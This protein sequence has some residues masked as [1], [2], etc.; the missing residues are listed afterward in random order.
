MSINRGVVK[1]III[2]SQNEIWGMNIEKGEKSVKWERL[3]L[4]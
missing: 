1:Y 4:H 3:D 2:L